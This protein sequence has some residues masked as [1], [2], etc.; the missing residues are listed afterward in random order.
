MT[1]R[2]VVSVR[3]ARFPGIGPINT[4]TILVEAGNLRRFRDPRLLRDKQDETLRWVDVAR[5]SSN[6]LERLT[7]PL[8]MR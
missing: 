2:G 7:K 1:T 5:G 6:A 8:L 4:M 3:R